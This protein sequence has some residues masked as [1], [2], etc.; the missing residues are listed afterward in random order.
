MRAFFSE[1]RRRRVLRTVTIYL[2][3]AWLLVEVSST[4]FPILDLPDW[5][6]RVVVILLAAGLPVVIVLSWIFDVDFGGIRRT[7]DLDRATPAA[8]ADT[9]Q[10]PPPNSVAVLPF[11]NVSNDPENAYFSDGISEELIDRL[12]RF[13]GLRV[14]ARTSSFAFRDSDA[15]IATVAARLKVRYVLEGSV[16]RDGSRVR[17][18]A[19]LV[20]AVPGYQRWA[21]TFDREIEH[22][23]DLQAD[24]AQSIVGAIESTI[25][26]SETRI[27]A[28]LPQSE[29]YVLDTEMGPSATFPT[30]DEPCPGPVD[31]GDPFVAP[32]APVAVDAGA[33]TADDEPGSAPPTRNIE[34]Y[35]H[36]L[37]G[38]YLWGKRG[39]MAIRGAINVLQKAV[40]LDPAFAEAYALLA[41]A[42]AT[43]HEYS[44]ESREADFDK[45]REHARYA[46]Q[47]DGSLSAPRAALGYMS[48]RTWDWDEADRHLSQAVAKDDTDPLI[49]QW[50][51]NFLNDV[52]RLD[53]ALD[54]ARRAH[55][56]DPVAAMSNTIVAF[57][58]MLHGMDAEACRHA[59]VAREFGVG[60]PVPDY[61]DYLA[62]LRSNRYADAEDTLTG[63][64]RRA[65]KRTDWAAPVVAALADEAATQAALEALADLDGKDRFVANARFVQYI[66]LGQPDP[67]F[68]HARRQLADRSL[69]HTWLMLPE[70]AA[71]RETAPFVD[72]M[73]RM[74]IVD[75]WDSH[76]WPGLVA[77]LREAPGDG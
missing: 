40:D 46:I 1:I 65:G 62:A 56:R 3:G 42:R 20:D 8:P 49:H 51:S 24:I 68:S 64:L 23:F 39:A 71:L 43:L 5:W 4:I 22:I 58:Y 48:M 37:R 21:Q 77:G 18:A 61:V 60:G 45:A 11:V 32:D 9:R 33:A 16:R 50:Y 53:E 70:A 76:G 13:P 28:A 63:M 2:A 69:N 6:S 10:P 35:E 47:L 31:P 7:E 14:P 55:D 54:E 19:R 38:R 41:C 52:G 66:L 26:A 12:A 30:G 75:Y 67:V 25:T 72:L 36:F 34:A 74:G 17:I 27:A 57:N 29:G 59:A 44:G 15:D 73:R